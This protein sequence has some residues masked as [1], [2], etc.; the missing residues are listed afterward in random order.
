MKVG[1]IVG[2]TTQPN[3][4]RLTLVDADDYDRETAIA[5][6]PTPLAK[7]V[8]LGHHIWTQ[9]GMAMLNGPGIPPDSKLW[10][11]RQDWDGYVWTLQEAQRGGRT[12]KREKGPTL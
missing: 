3:R 7:L 10:I 6:Y 2:I 12:M 8:E 5:V 1:T 4:I 9:C 11:I